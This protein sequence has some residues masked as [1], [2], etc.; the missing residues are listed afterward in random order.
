MYPDIKNARRKTYLGMVTAMDD[1]LK[2]LVED[3]KSQNMY[4]NSIIVFFAQHPCAFF[5][6]PDKMF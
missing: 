1:V 2:N 4:E 5:H 3:L 6:L